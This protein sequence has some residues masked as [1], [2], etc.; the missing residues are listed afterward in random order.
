MQQDLACWVALLH[1]KSLFDSMVAKLVVVWIHFSIERRYKTSYYSLII[2]L[3]LTSSLKTLHHHFGLNFSLSLFI[4]KVVFS[5]RSLSSR[6]FIHNFLPSKDVP[7]QRWSP[8]IG[9]TLKWGQ[10]S[11]L[12]F[13]N[14]LEYSGKFKTIS[15]GLAFVVVLY[16]CSS[17]V[18][19]CI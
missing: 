15:I 10:D 17:C 8:L 18:R 4:S 9:W 6:Y 5:H 16:C 12:G 19:G 14:L 3:Q 1:F 13:L 7:H 11:G 2:L